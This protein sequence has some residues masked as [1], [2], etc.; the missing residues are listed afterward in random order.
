MQKGQ[1]DGVFRGAMAL[2]LNP[3]IP[4]SYSI[5]R[6][7]AVGTIIMNEFRTFERIVLTDKAL[8]SEE[9][10]KGGFIPLVR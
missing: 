3:I 4:R 7:M 9:T 5:D 8:L 10:V 2:S 6:C 1:V